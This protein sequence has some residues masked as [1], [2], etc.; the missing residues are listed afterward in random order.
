MIVNTSLEIQLVCKNLSSSDQVGTPWQGLS[1]PSC[2]LLFLSVIRLS[3]TIEGWEGLETWGDG[4]RA[5]FTNP[6]ATPLFAQQ[7]QPMEVSTFFYMDN[8]VKTMP[9]EFPVCSLSHVDGSLQFHS[10]LVFGVC[11]YTEF[12]MRKL[13]GQ[14]GYSLYYRDIG[15][16]S[17]LLKGRNFE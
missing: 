10:S 16:L 13:F 7:V 8:V 3:V 5:P 9:Y 17:P 6:L 2:S 15:I 1:T 4:T 14:H 11:M 12:W